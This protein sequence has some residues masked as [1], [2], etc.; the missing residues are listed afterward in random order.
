MHAYA[1]PQHD[2]AYKRSDELPFETRRELAWIAAMTWGAD[3]AYQ[4]VYERVESD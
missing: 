1:E 2:F 3:K 4:R